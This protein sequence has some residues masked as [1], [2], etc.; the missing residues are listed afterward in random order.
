MLNSPNNRVKDRDCPVIQDVITGLNL[1]EEVPQGK[2]D[3]AGEKE[4]K[5][6]FGQKSYICHGSNK[7]Q[8]GK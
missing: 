6:I 5:I 8:E 1:L 3:K 7:T 4:H 2:Q